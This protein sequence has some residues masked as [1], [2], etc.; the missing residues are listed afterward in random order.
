M[1]FTPNQPVEQRG[2]DVTVDAGLAA[3]VYRFR[4][5]VVGAQSGRKS[6]PMEVLVRVQGRV[7]IPVPGPAPIPGPIIIDR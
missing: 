2:P 4:L 1:K 7:P 3:G 5:E 6:K